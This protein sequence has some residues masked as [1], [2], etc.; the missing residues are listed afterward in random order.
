MIGLAVLLVAGS[1]LGTMAYMTDNDSAK[2]VMTVGNVNIEQYEKD[3]AG[4]PFVQN[5]HFYPMVDLREEGE[6]VLVTGTNGELVYH[7]NMQNVIDKFVTVKNTGSESAYVRTI[8]AFETKRAYK[9]NSTTEFVDLHDQFFGVNGTFDYLDEYIVIDGVE[10]ILAVCVY[11]DA[12]APGATTPASL[13]QIF[14]SPD[15]TNNAQE[16]FGSQYDILA[17]SQAVQVNGFETKGAD[18]ALN[19][20]F[21]EVTAATASAWFAPIAAQ[22]VQ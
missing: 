21:G 7:P 20:A 9:E 18:F 2:N 15:A 14:L 11:E 3:E 5:Q 1:V 4:E 16:Q 13:R 19:T 10:Y 6:A 8:L 12:L 17:L 22:Q